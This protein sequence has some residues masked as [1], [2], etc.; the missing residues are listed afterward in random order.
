MRVR[1]LAK[2]IS[3]EYAQFGINVNT[4]C[5][6]NT[7]TPMNQHIQDNPELVTWI[8]ERTP[9]R[10]TYLSTQEVADVVL[11]LASDKAS[12]IHGADIPVDDGW[13]IG[14]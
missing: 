8:K 2:A 11:F 3:T 4:V 14:G 9:T 10:R 13:L 7:A 6:G 12:A 5:P 1:R